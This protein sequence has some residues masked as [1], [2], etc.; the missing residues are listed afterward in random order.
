[1]GG[2]PFLN[3]QKNNAKQQKK[4]KNEIGGLPPI[5]S[6]HRGGWYKWKQG[7]TETNKTTHEHMQKN[8]SVWVTFD[9]YDLRV[10]G[11]ISMLMCFSFG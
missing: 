10:W 5:F 11:D 6:V 1:M 2:F 3:F 9:E 7:S 8:K 4:Q